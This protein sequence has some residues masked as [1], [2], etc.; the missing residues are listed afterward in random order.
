M[1]DCA[2]TPT[3]AEL[4][5][6]ITRDIKACPDWIGSKSG[7]TVLDKILRRHLSRLPCFAGRAEAAPEPEP[8][9]DPE[10]THRDLAAALLREHP[11]WIDL[12]AIGTYSWTFHHEADG[13]RYGVLQGAAEGHHY[14]LYSGRPLETE[15][16]FEKL[17]DGRVGDCI[18]L[19]NTATPE[20]TDA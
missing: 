16:F 7:N 20:G 13:K 18:A 17:E 8:E 2:D 3:L 1:P 4:C 6:V 14:S 10:P 12:A 9:C 11:D 19:V 5:R 15:H